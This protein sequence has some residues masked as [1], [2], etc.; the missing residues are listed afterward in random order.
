MAKE[1]ILLGGGCF[2]CVEAVFSRV[3]GVE[4][5]KSGYS[6]GDKQSANYEAVCSKTT[7]HIEVVEIIFDNSIIELDDILEIFFEIHDPTTIDRQGADA[8]PQYRSAIFY[9]TKEQELT[10]LEL[11]ETIEKDKNINIV[12]KLYKEVEFF[13]AEDYH[14]NYYNLNPNA[15]YCSF[16]ITP[17]VQKFMTNFKEFIK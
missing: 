16:V 7:S 2:W 1:K 11:I 3:K 9:N 4:S 8:G 13:V 14:L 5:A 6:G 15:G 17:K 10:T 12:T